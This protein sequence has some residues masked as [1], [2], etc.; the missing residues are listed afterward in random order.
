MGIIS[1]IQFSTTRAEIIPRVGTTQTVERS[2]YCLPFSSRSRDASMSRLWNPRSP[3]MM[4]CRLRHGSR[5]SSISTSSRLER[6]P[7]GTPAV[8]V[9]R[10]P[11]A[12]RRCRRGGRTEDAVDS[13]PCVARSGVGNL[14][15][16]GVI[17]CRSVHPRAV[18]KSP[19]HP[20]TTSPAC[21]VVN[22]PPS[23]LSLAGGAPS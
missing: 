8:G 9:G 4:I 21:V 2:R 19:H 13:G 22:V 5:L 3:P 17:G 16:L 15:A 11:T 18:L 6:N 1:P 7:D 23:Q 12:L 20:S 14:V 10:G